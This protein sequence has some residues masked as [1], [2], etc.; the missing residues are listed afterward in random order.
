MKKTYLKP[1]TECL[2]IK[3]DA[4]LLGVSNDTNAD[5]SQPVLS[6]DRIFMDLEDEDFE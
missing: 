5:S 3:F 4:I 2:D 6:K 1:E